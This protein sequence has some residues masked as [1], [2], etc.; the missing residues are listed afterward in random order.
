MVT[1]TAIKEIQAGIRKNNQRIGSNINGTGCEMDARGM[2]I[3]SKVNMAKGNTSR[4]LCLMANPN[5]TQ[6]QQILPRHEQN[7]KRAHESNA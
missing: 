2:R 7:S 5:Q 1:T 3:P 6:R 4:K